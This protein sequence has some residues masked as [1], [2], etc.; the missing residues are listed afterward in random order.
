MD[1]LLAAAG[2]M[3]PPKRKRDFHRK[4]QPTAHK[5]VDRGEQKEAV[6]PSTNSILASTR[7]PTSFHSRNLATG[8]G[9]EP[10]RPDASI[11]KIADKKLRAKVARSDVAGKRARQERAEVDEWLNQAVSGG[12][13]GIEVEEDEGE[14]TWRVG[15]DEIVEA[16]GVSNAHKRFDLKFESMGNYMVD[17]TRNGRHLAI[18]SQKGHVAT[19]DWKAGKLNAEIQLREAVRDIK[20]LQNE[21][22]F[23]VAQKKYVFVYDRNGVELHKLKDHIDPV[24]MEYLPYHYLLS[25]VVSTLRISTL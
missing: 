20:F 6:D 11:S 24:H 19:F 17:Y 10:L 2:P 18:A 25:T 9:D 8:K 1:A 21:D 5:T 15:Q 7:M 12:Q 4:G 16:V 3:R 22:F 14:R 13:G 23:A